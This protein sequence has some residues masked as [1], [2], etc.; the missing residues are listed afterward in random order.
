MINPEIKKQLTKENYE[1]VGEHSA[2]KICSWTKKSLRDEGVCYKEKFYG[3][4]SHLC[5]QMTPAL[6]NC[7]NKCIHCWRNLEYSNP[8]EVKNP[9]DPKKII[10]GAIKAQQKLLTGFKIDPN[11]KKKQLSRANQEKYQ[12]AQEPMQFAISLTGEPTLYPLIGDLIEELTKRK[13][14]ILLG[15]QRTLPRKITRN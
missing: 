15:N 2:V 13:K 7:Q 10:D 4:K 8:T 12:E 14:N 9:E 11:S 5:C 6:F 1:V 3:I